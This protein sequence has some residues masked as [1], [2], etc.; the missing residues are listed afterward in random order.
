MKLLASSPTKERLLNMA[1]S[2][3][4]SPNIVL[5]DDGSISNSKGI[6]SGVCWKQKKDRLEW[7]LYREC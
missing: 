7:S 6:I 1:K 3:Y 4:C 2:F 5:N